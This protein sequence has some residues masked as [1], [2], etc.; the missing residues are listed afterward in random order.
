MSEYKRL[1]KIA[2][3]FEKQLMVVMQDSLT[4]TLERDM[5]HALDSTTYLI[6]VLEYRQKQGEHE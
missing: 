1:L 6:E 2:K 5:N 4:E 3:M